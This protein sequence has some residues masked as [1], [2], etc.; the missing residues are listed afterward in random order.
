MWSQNNLTLKGIGKK[1]WT[2]A[3]SI[4]RS[5]R[6]SRPIALMYTTRLS[7][8]LLDQRFPTRCACKLPFGIHLPSWNGTF[9][10]TLPWTTNKNWVKSL[11]RAALSGALLKL[12][13]KHS[14]IFP[15]KTPVPLCG[16]F[17][18]AVLPIASFASW[19]NWCSS[20]TNPHCVQPQSRYTKLTNT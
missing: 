6:N 8:Q 17:S 2:T 9:L 5:D 20:E 3:L 16:P 1:I 11:M 14:S 12:P 4:H 18:P 10:I 13:A 19:A 15:H 7:W